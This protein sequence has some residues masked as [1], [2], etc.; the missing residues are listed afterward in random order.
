MMPR[1]ERLAV[2]SVPLA[3]AGSLEAVSAQPVQEPPDCQVSTFSGEVAR[4]RPFEQP[5]ADGLLFRLSPATHPSNPQGWTIEVRNAA[6]PLHDYVSVTTPPYRSF[7]PRDLT[8]SYGYTSESVVAISPRH[9]RCV[10]AE[11]DRARLA[12]A[13]G[14]LLWPADRSSEEIE[15]AEQL[16]ERMEKGDG[17]FTIVDYRLSEPNGEHP[18]GVIES[19]RFEVRL[20]V[21]KDHTA[22][23]SRLMSQLNSQF[24]KWNERLESV[25]IVEAQAIPEDSGRASAN[26]EQLAVLA[27]AHTA[28]RVFEQ[29]LEDEAYGIFV[30]RT[31]SLH[32]VET[33]DIFPTCRWLDCDV[34][35]DHV[36]A[37]SIAVRW[38][39]AT[40]GDQEGR[41]VY[42]LP[43]RE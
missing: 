18:L 20:C 29:R 38:E 6:Y 24:R 17:V 25:D 28:D 16:M 11:I 37:D 5:F 3:V 8:T 43:H 39:G 14:R 12:S 22:H 10:F 13:L 30:V 21:P 26:D 27:V 36:S 32:L 34:R 9:F 23:S 4:G 19:L 33:I 31:D 2:L 41:A 42:P 35:L 7:Y 1:F 15:A 40:Y